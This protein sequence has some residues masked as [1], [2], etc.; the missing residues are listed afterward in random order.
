MKHTRIKCTQKVHG[1]DASF[2]IDFVQKIITTNSFLMINFEVKTQILPKELFQRA[3][4]S[5]FK[6][7][8]WRF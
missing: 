4:T 2:D 5:V 1:F 6:W 8:L 3:C 7:S